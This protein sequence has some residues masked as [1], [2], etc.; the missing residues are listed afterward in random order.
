MR[1]RKPNT[2]HRNEILNTNQFDVQL[3]SWMNKAYAS[4]CWLRLVTHPVQHLISPCGDNRCFKERQ[5]QIAS[6]FH[7]YFVSPNQLWITY[8]WDKILIYMCLNIYTNIYRKK[9]VIIYFLFHS[10]LYQYIQDQW[11]HSLSR[12]LLQWLGDLFA[13][14]FFLIPEISCVVACVHY[15]SPF[16][17]ALPRSLAPPFVYIS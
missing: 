1:N 3:V 14:I 7:T 2:E 12:P 6:V 17:S 10:Q 9:S 15:L 4:K 13:S 5:K 11:L 16:H 8:Y